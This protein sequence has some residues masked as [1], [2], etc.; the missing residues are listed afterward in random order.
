MSGKAAERIAVVTASARSLPDL[1]NSMAF[2]MAVVEEKMGEVSPNKVD[3][4]RE[5]M[6]QAR[7]ASSAGN[8]KTCEQA[9][10]RVRC[11]MHP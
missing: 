1:T 10:T 7:A 3:A 5:A 11:L 9:L 2:G 8:Y 6:A 4:I